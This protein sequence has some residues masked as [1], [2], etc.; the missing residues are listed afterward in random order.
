MWPTLL[1]AWIT[2]SIF[3]IP[4]PFI[5]CPMPQR[6]KTHFYMKMYIVPTWSAAQSWQAGFLQSYVHWQGCWHI[7]CWKDAS[8][9]Y[10]WQDEW[11]NWDF[12]SII[13]ALERLISQGPQTM[14]KS[15]LG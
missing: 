5:R 12:M 3:S 9:I 10:H 2:S 1:L 7:E 4:E 13:F 8:W 15:T 11:M 14:R 6:I